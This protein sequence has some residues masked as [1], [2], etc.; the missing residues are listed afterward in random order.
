[1]KP[2]DNVIDATNYLEDVLLR[3]TELNKGAS[4]E[5]LMGLAYASLS[6]GIKS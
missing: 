5:E 6:P 2:D 3:V 1:M 4:R